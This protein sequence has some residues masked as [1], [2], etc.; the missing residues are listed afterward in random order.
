MNKTTQR[1]NRNRRRSNRS[2]SFRE[3]KKIRKINKISDHFSRKDFTCSCNECKQT[4]K[5]GLGLVG[6]LELLRSTLKARINIIKGYECPAAAEKQGKVKRNFHT[7]GLAADIQ[8]EGKTIQEVFLAAE[9]IP[10]FNGLGLN[11]TENY[12]H[13]DARKAPEKTLWVEENDDIIP[14]ENTNRATYFPS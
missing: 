6:G 5:L 13:V 12:V 14:L 4:I 3:P 8:V 1:K 9:T 10:D 7:Q 2:Q 11:V